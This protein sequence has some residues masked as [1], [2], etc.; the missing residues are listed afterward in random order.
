M[1]YTLNY[2][3]TG[4]MDAENVIITT[5]LPIT[6]T[7]AGGGWD[8]SDDQTY[9]Y[10]VGSL[11]SAQSG[12]ILFVVQYPLT[13]PQQIAVSEFNVPFVIAASN[14][15]GE[16]A[17]PV[18]NS[19]EHLIGVPDL[20]VTYFTVAPFPLLPD[21]PVTFTVAIKNQGTGLACIPSNGAG[22]WIDIYNEPIQSYP[23]ERF[24]D[25]WD[26]SPPIQPDGIFTITIYHSGFTKKQ[27]DEFDA[28]YVKVDNNWG[29]PYGLVPESNEY[30]NVG[31]PFILH[32]NRV[33]LPMVQR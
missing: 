2:S 5:V 30:N 32:P 19:A 1:T 14:G 6:L 31:E 16:D 15:T 29:S 13:E 17:N 8:T 18:N 23:D 3:N 12:D 7:Y 20:I 28:F 26:G 11:E 25:Y 9:T 27:L 24:G 4:K 21:A 22:F 33:Y 10:T